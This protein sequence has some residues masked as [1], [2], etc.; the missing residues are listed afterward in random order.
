MNTAIQT[1]IRKIGARVCVVGLLLAGLANG[2]ADV[3]IVD[4]VRVGAA[5]TA[6]AV[7]ATFPVFVLPLG[8]Q[9]TDFEL[10]ASTNNFATLA[11]FYQSNGT[12]LSNDFVDPSPYVYFTDDYSTDVRQWHAKTIS[13]GSILSLL[14]SPNSVVEA[15]IFCPSHDA[16]APWSDWM[17]ATNTHLVWSYVRLDNMGAQMNL[18]GT[19][20][21]WTPIRPTSWEVERPGP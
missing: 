15:V 16:A 12:P 10:K 3:W 6:P 5:V 13:D 1:G 8:G 18:D 14:A 4:G 21:R 19:K 7:D 20:T 17:Y 2:R 9:W 11:Y